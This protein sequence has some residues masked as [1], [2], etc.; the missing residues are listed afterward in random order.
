[1]KHGCDANSAGPL[2]LST[3]ELEGEL[4]GLDELSEAMSSVMFPNWEGVRD[5]MDRWQRRED[6]IRA[7]LA[8]RVRSRK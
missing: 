8:R 7:E 3:E 5:V 6:A 1:M 2:D 4:V